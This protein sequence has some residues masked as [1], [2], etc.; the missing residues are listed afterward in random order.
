V[1][2]CPVSHCGVSVDFTHNNDNLFLPS[3]G[4][5]GELFL[6]DVVVDDD[7]FTLSRGKIYTCWHR[8]DG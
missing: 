1:G 7:G 6:Y 3:S 5:S 2:M 8:A 4:Y